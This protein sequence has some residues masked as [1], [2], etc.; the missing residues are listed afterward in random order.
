MSFTHE[1]SR[2]TTPTLAPDGKARFERSVVLVGAR[3][4]VAALT[5]RGQREQRLD[6]VLELGNAVRDHARTRH[7]IAHETL[8]IIDES[9]LEGDDGPHNTLLQFDR[10]SDACHECLRVV[11]QT[12]KHTNQVTQY[13]VRLGRVR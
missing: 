2:Q 7:Q 11:G 5:L 9:L 8:E 13:G 10:A 3:Y 1:P 6:P 4:A 12:F